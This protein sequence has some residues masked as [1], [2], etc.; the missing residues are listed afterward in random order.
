MSCLILIHFFNLYFITRH[1]KLKQFLVRHKRL[2]MMAVLWNCWLPPQISLPFSM[3]KHLSRGQTCLA[4]LSANVIANYDSLLVPQQVNASVCSVCLT[5]S[6]R[7]IGL[8]WP[9]GSKGVLYEGN[10]SNILSYSDTWRWQDGISRTWWFR[11]WW[12]SAGRQV[13]GLWH[14]SHRGSQRF[15]HILMSHY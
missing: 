9:L 5:G 6:Y 2:F 12:C 3:L 15:P 11:E 10:C 8:L 14:S 4:S 7:W 1:N 13:W